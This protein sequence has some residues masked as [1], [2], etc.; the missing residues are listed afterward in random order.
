VDIRRTDFGDRLTDKQIAETVKD[1][2]D[3]DMQRYVENQRYVRG[4]NVFINDRVSPDPNAPDN[5]VPISYGRKIVN[6]IVGY[7]YKPGLVR[8]A[9]ENEGRMEA[10]QEVFDANKEPIKTA[11]LGKQTSTQGVGYEFHYVGGTMGA[12]GVRAVPRFAMLPADQVIPLYDFEVE[13]NLRAFIRFYAR[14]EAIQ[15]FAYY[16]KAWEHYTMD[17][18]GEQAKAVLVEVGVHPY[19]MVPLNVYYNNDEMIGDFDPV[20]PLID[21]YDVLMSD[22]MNEFDRF[23]WAYL[24]LKGFGLSAADADAIKWKRVFENLDAEDAVSFL[25]KEIPTEFVKFMAEWCR[26]EIHNQSGIPDVTDIKFGAAAS[27]TTIDKFIYLMELFT[28][29]KEALFRDGLQRRIEMID[30]VLKIRDGNTGAEQ[31]EITMSRNLPTD[32][33]RNAETLEKYSGHVTEK[34]LLQEFAPFVKD[35]DAEIAEMEAEKAANIERM[36]ST[37]P[38]EDEEMPDVPPGA[39]E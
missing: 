33:Y 5:K 24:L 20:R 21:A 27:G 37:M 30:A 7:M 18:E 12:E 22:S 17:S 23:A 38:D 31:I 2:M 8:Y 10:L 9:S 6:T 4:D 39:A 1:F 26:G 25:T 19:P 36:M 34:T 15:V 3:T 14:D 28:D 32:N 29:P 11:Q 16:P 35:V 13:P